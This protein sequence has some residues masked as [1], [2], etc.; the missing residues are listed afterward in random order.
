[1]K[2]FY[3]FIFCLSIS[4]IQCAPPQNTVS[5][6]TFNLRYGTADDGDNSW[7]FR[8]DMLIECIQQYN[9]DILGVQEALPMQIE[10]ISSAFK[11]YKVFGVGRYYNVEIDERPQES[12]N[13]ESCNIFYN[14]KKFELLDH[15]TFWHSDTPDVPASMTWG[16]NLPRITTWGILKDLQTDKQFVVFNNHYDGREP[17]ASNTTKL[18]LKKWKEI[19]GE[20]PSIFMGDFNLEPS[21]VGHQMFCEPDQNDLLKGNFVDVWQA[22]NKDEENAG[23]SND[24]NGRKDKARIDWFLTTKNIKAEKIEIVYF[25]KNGRYPSDHYPV[26]TELSF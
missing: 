17:C 1:M 20:K 18:N 3:L 15:G 24:F 25:N 19:A 13:G 5:I 14:A 23:T 22:L 11:D 2:K 16:N 21:S 6:M 10:K 4:L 7:E 8:K 12:M 9:P 26:Y